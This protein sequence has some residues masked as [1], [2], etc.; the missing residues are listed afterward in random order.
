MT[1]V[2]RNSLG[3]MEKDYDEVS[4]SSPFKSIAKSF[5]LKKLASI[6]LLSSAL[7]ST[8]L[9]S[10]SLAAQSGSRSGGSSFRSSSSYRSSTRLNSMGNSYSYN[11]PTIIPVP[12]APLF[13]PF[14]FGFGFPSFGFGW[15]YGISPFSLFNPNI[16]LMGGLAYAAY[17]LLK[18]RIGGSD[19]SDDGDVGSLGEGASVVRLQ[20]ALD[21]DWTRSNNVMQTFAALASRRG[22]VTGRTEIAELLSDASLNLLRKQTN[23]VAASITGERFRPGQSARAEPFFQQL[24]VQERAK[25]EKETTNNRISVGSDRIIDVT[26]GQQR[27]GATK[28]V[29][30]IVAAIRGQSRSLDYKDFRS[31]KD[32]ASCLQALASEALTDEGENV[33]AVEVLWTPSEVSDVLTNKDMIVDY[34]ELRSL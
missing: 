28:A 7:L 8:Q 34:P 25:F 32:V 27:G 30:S 24:A 33:L 17:L 20:I 23:W 15:G 29:V 16:L 26:E 13:S 5:D 9:P 19:F 31:V 3:M 1:R 10:D 4:K 18:N 12:T 14:S 22:V 2:R 11:S 21:D 6:T